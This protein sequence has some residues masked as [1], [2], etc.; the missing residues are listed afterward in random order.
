MGLRPRPWYFAAALVAS[1]AA[2]GCPKEPPPEPRPTPIS[3]DVHLPSERPTATDVPVVRDAGRVAT[4]DLSFW[5]E[6]YP[7]SY[8]PTERV[9]ELQR[10]V[11]AEGDRDRR[12]SAAFLLGRRTPRESIGSVASVIPADLLDAF[13]R[14]LAGR[15]RDQAPRTVPERLLP[16][17]QQ[18]EPSVGVA[19]LAS[20]FRITIPGLQ[21]SDVV[22]M[23]L[24][25]R[26][27]ARTAGTR[28]VAVPGVS[29]IGS[30]VYSALDQT[31]MASLVQSLGKRRDVPGDVWTTL[32]DLVRVR[33][34]AHPRAWA[35][36]WRAV[37]DTLPQN[38]ERLTIALQTAI[39]AVDD[40][41]LGAPSVNAAM[42]CE[43]AGVLSRNVPSP[44][45]V[46][47]CATGTERWR[48][49][50]TLAG[51]WGTR[52]IDPRMRADGLRQILQEAQGEVHVLEAV[53]PSVVN[54]PVNLARPML[55][56]LASSTDPGVLASLLEALADESEPLHVQHLRAMTPAA[57]SALLHAPFLLP[58]PSSIEARIHAINL[59]RRLGV[60]LP[61]TASE[62]RALQ[63]ARDPD[64]GVLPSPT[65][66]A[67]PS[68]AGV[69]VIHT[70]RGA[71]HVELRA[72]TAPR[73][74]EFVTGAARSGRYNGTSF[75]RVVPAF[76]AQG[77]DPR[78]DGYGGTET[79]IPT[80]V[81]GERFDRGAV[82]IAL[83]GL[84]TGGL[85]FFI[86]TAD[87][88]HLD[89][90]YPWIGRV[91]RGME[92][93]DELLVGD[94]MQRVEVLPAP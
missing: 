26:M 46:L 2:T 28:L 10:L 89:G 79:I 3:L 44:G 49:L 23:S 14:G 82:G 60:V 69:M 88:P 29:V 42:R 4:R 16:L 12:L 66:I 9:A 92:V 11:A 71:I 86:V 19:T 70:L 94:V 15:A 77:G 81:S 56:T 45:R 74:L 33:Y 68:V 57:R 47:A 53:A 20:R 93:A 80:E 43:N 13:A 24:D 30:E 38:D 61:G 41:D 32:L 54:L 64:A 85:Q 31:S 51:V 39:G 55:T 67:P 48:A 84:D 18:A 50:A 73:A 59:A 62:S 83:A 5:E 27:E 76:V 65:T 34:R 58:E 87:A 1:L 36:A 75:H 72:D 35:N 52:S 6:A 78:G 8:L 7:S 17:L 21:S 63:H 90:R 91:V 25:G 22:R 37:R 40:A